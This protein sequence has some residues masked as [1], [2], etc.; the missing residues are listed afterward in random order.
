[1]V[2]LGGATVVPGFVDMHVHGGGGRSFDSGTAG[3]APPSRPPTCAHGTTSMLASLVT[4]PH[5][6]MVCS[7]RELALLVA[8]GVLAGVHLEGPWLARDARARTSP[9]PCSEPARRR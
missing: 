1:M 3:P 9:A 5:P 4:D 6:A 7:V 2:D 8:D